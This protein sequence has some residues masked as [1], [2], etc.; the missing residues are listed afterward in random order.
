MGEFITFLFEHFA[1][2]ISLLV[3]M[4]AAYLAGCNNF[5]IR[6]ANACIVFRA[7]ILNELGSIYPHPVEWP[8]SIDIFLRSHFISLQKAVENFRAYVPWWNRWR[9]DRAWFRYRCATGRE[10]DIQCYHHYMAFD[11]N[12]DYKDT[13][14]K[15]VSYLL[16]FANET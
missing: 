7:A 9:F 1:A 11:D 4:L 5:K 14:Y 13:F 10:V 3:V 8:E 2:I 15:N 6:R 16:S 12:P